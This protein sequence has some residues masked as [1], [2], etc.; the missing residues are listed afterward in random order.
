MCNLLTRCAFYDNSVNNHGD[1]V[2]FLLLCLL[3]KQLFID[4]EN[5]SAWEYFCRLCVNV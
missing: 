1:V 3:A 5:A 2:F 4:C